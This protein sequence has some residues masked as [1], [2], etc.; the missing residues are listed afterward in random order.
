MS[1]CRAHRSRPWRLWRLPTARVAVAAGGATVV[2]AAAAGFLPGSPWPSAGVLVAG[3]AG[4]AG[5][6]RRHRGRLAVE[7]RMLRALR[8]TTPRCP[9]DTEVAG[10]TAGVTAAT[11]GDG[12]IRI[13]A[14]SYHDAIRA[15]GHAMGCDRGF[16][17]DLM[18]R[19]GSGTLAEVWGRGALPSDTAFRK[20]GL[21]AAADRAAAALAAPERDLLAAF[22]DGVTAA[23][24]RETPFEARFLSYRPKPWRV[25][26]SVLVALV[27][28]HSL[29]WNERAKRA[30]AV[31]RATLPDEVADFLL[32]V[33]GG[34]TPPVPDRLAA[35]RAAVPA[36]WPGVA[37]DGLVALDRVVAGTNCWVTAKGGTPLLACD[38]HLS[39][40]VPN[41]L[42][43]VDLSW[44]GTR[45]RGLAAPGLPVVLTG[46]N[47]RI[48]WGVT[49]LT[50]D[51]LDLVPTSAATQ[52]TTTERIRVRGREAAEV[53]VTTDDGLP[54]AD[55]P[56]CGEQVAVRW[57]GHDPRAA[58]LRFQRLAAARD[59]AEA[60]AVLDDAEGVALNLLV[61][62][63]DGRMAHLATGLL[64]RRK[65]G[66]PRTDPADGHLTGAERPRVADPADRILVSAN[67]E[68]LPE[69]PH[70]I[71]LDLD[72]GYRAGRIRTV[73]SGQTAPDAAAMHALQH[74]TDAALYRPY[75]DLAVAAL[76]PGP[77]RSLLA[78]WDG[79]A[80]AG[81]RAFGVLVRLRDLLAQRVLTPYLVACRAAD[82]TFTFPFRALDRPLLA[83][84]ATRDPALLPEG[85]AGADAFVAD[86]VAT[87][88]A[89]VGGA[90]PRR[91]GRLNRVGLSHP[92]AGLAPWADAV[93]GLRPRPQDGM[94]HSVRTAVAGFGAAGRIV[95]TPH[96]VA[97]VALPA[98]Q[99]GHPLSPH[100]ADRHAAWASSSRPRLRAGAR[101]RRDGCGFTLRPH[102]ARPADQTAD[103]LACEG[104]ESR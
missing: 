1:G 64:P 9:G 6:A 55:Q 20:L 98:G 22:A 82:P 99:S 30:D 63:G 3:A 37:R 28:F 8:E 12:V 100:Y 73:L 23:Y 46:T 94:L 51:V 81:S 88:V 87:A 27:L 7:T 34:R 77:V 84:L 40:G 86:C 48:A 45:L 42:Y 53:T 11:G 58:D 21:A 10:L 18:R 66:T 78:G 36:G 35:H 43:E 91:W 59:V 92:L 57:T 49:N 56:L 90:R 68:G 79:T 54:V 85:T 26:D 16:Q 102:R 44:P 15:L 74:D 5:Y 32:P 71:G 104:E 19:T 96:D 33:T 29:S 25:E 75:R 80:G 31:V 14:R 4:I 38:P 52:T 103:V 76:P 101:A 24:A 13:T 70:R 83:I 2:L 17:L 67:D 95:L 89:D 72:P 62:D 41:A 50:A 93:L 65:A 39:L 69:E 60:V 61:T 97:S 47:G